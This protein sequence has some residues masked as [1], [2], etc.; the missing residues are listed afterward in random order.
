RS[1]LE[2]AP[3]PL[4][5]GGAFLAGQPV[6]QVDVRFGNPV[7]RRETHRLIEPLERHGGPVH[8]L[9]YA[10]VQRLRT[11]RNPTESQ[12]GDDRHLLGT[13]DLGRTLD[14]TYDVGLERRE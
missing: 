14:A 9:Q 5:E 10:G 2:D 3:H 4:M 11:E 6:D 1:E 7:L 13:R 8:G 12:R